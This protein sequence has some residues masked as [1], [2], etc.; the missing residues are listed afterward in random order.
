MTPEQIEERIMQLKDNIDQGK[1]ELENLKQK[2]LLSYS[3][4]EQIRINAKKQMDKEK[5]TGIKVYSAKMCDVVEHLDE[6]ISHIPP[7]KAKEDADLEV[8]LEGLIGIR[9]LFVKAIASYNQEIVNERFGNRFE[10]EE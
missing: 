2:L 1:E 4:R 3:Q 9:R 8:I 10:E 5:E 6:C 7:E